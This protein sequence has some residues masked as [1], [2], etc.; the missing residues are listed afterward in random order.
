MEQVVEVL[1]R[2][3]GGEPAAAFPEEEP[4]YADDRPAFGQLGAMCVDR[5]GNLL[6]ATQRAL[7][8]SK[9]WNAA[10]D[11][12]DAALRPLHLP[13]RV[14]ALYAAA[15]AAACRSERMLPARMPG[16]W[17]LHHPVCPELTLTVDTDARQSQPD[18]TGCC[19]LWLEEKPVLAR[20]QSLSPSERRVALLVVQGL[21]NHEIAETLCRS[22]RTVEFQLN[23][24][25]R[26]LEVSCRTQLVRALL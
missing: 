1:Q 8:L 3:G 26:K 20:L 17:T 22:R 7:E 19:L 2:Y 4:R 18:F 12:S 16:R 15:F 23:S 10:L 6:F 5:R 24:I 14:D 13:N 21:R 9:R 11:Q 25:Y